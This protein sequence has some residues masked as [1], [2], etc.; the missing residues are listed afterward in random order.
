MKRRNML[1]NV[2]VISDVVYKYLKERKGM[3]DELWQKRK[4]IIFKFLHH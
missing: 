1:F 4:R 2:G 3:N